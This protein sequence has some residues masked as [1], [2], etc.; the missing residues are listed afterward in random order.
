MQLLKKGYNLTVKPH[1][2]AGSKRE[3]ALFNQIKRRAK[4][5]NKPI[6]IMK[7]S[8]LAEKLIKDTDI[9]ITCIS[10]G[11]NAALGNGIPVIY[12]D[13]P[14]NKNQALNKLNKKNEIILV[15]DWH[16]AIH[17]ADSIMKN[18]ILFSYWKKKGYSSLIKL[19][20]NPEIFDK[21]WIRLISNV[22]KEKIH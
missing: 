20:G 15:K 14:F 17:Q 7:R 3:I 4:A 6:K 2:R 18:P 22:L 16:Q 5:I 12:V 8:I 13:T 10:A 11:A 21:S 1:P 9:V 19:S